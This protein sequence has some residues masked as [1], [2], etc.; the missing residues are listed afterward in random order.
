LLTDGATEIDFFHVK[1]PEGSG[2]SKM[3][4]L[5]VHKDKFKKS[6]RAIVRI[7]SPKD[8]LCLPRAIAVTRMHSQKPQVFDLEWEKKW[9]RIR[10]GDTLE[11]KLQAVALMEEAGCDTSQP[12]DN[13]HLLRMADEITLPC[14]KIGN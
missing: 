3:K 2:G 10:L 8:S 5:H 9:L 11:Q 4:H 1:Y 13:R 7:R 12:C 6:K 14:S